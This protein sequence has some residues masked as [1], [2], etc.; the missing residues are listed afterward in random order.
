MRAVDVGGSAAVLSKTNVGVL[1]QIVF[2]V[3]DRT[4]PTD[5]YNG[6]F[7]IQESDFIGSHE[8]PAGELGALTERSVAPFALAA[9]FSGDRFLAQLLRDILV[10][11]LLVAAEVNHRIGVADDAL[12]V[13]FEQG[14]ELR[15]VLQD[16]R[17]RDVA[18]S[19]G[20]LQ[21]GVAVRQGDVGKFVE[22][23]AHRHGQTAHVHLVRLVVQLLESLRIQEPYK[24]VE[25]IVVAV[26]DHTENGLLSLAQPG[27]FQRVF[28]GDVLDLPQRE[29]SQTD[30]SGHK[31]AFRRLA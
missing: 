2:L 16:D 26:G 18:G 4:L 8:F 9:G 19:H 30:S 17:G 10:R 13:V 7:V 11:A 1:H 24:A 6:V 21:A 23:E 20:R 25:R 27:Q 14:F 15:Y 28:I 22:H 12:P 5:N 29:G 31:N 3:D